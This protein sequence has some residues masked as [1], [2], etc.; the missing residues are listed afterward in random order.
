MIFFWI[1]FAFLVSQRF[2]ELALA[3]HNEQIVKSKGALEFDRDGYRYIV[4]MHVAFFICLVLE[5]FSLQ[6]ELNKFWVVF[7]LI[8]LT[9]QI[10]RYWAISSLGVYWNTK[11][12]VVPGFQRTTKGP[13]KYLKHP[14]YIAV[15]VEI[16]VIPLVFSCYLT[17]VLF[18]IVNFILVRRRIKIEENALGN[19][20][21]RVT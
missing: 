4:A 12:L 1:F 14:N 19:I 21:G 13:Y 9:A 5:K 7:L 2:F 18:S 15:I 16:A 8:F 10:L 6:R 3:K 20:S 11:V 17:S